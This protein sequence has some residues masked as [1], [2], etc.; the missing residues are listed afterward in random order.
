MKRITWL[1]SALWIGA[2]APPSSAFT[3]L[4]LATGDEA[5]PLDG[6]SAGMG[7]TRFAQDTRGF[8]ASTNPALLTRLQRGTVSL[9]LGAHRLKET[10]STPAFDSFESF[11]VNS[12]YALNN[13]PKYQGG[14]GVAGTVGQERLPNG[15]G[16]GLSFGPVW[17]YQYEFTQEIRSPDPFIRPRDQLIA[18]NDF[19]SDGR[20]D[21]WTLGVGIAPWKKFEFG[22]S[23][24]FLEGSQELLQRVNLV[25]EETVTTEAASIHSLTGGRFILGASLRATPH[26]DFAALVKTRATLDGNFRLAGSPT[27]TP[28]V[29]Q[30][31]PSSGSAEIRYPAQ[32][33]FGV[34]YYPRAKVRTTVTLDLGYTSWSDYR[35]TLHPGIDLDDTWDARVG[36]EHVFRE[37]YPMRFGFHYRPSPQDLEIAS[38]A[39]TFGLGMD[40]WLL[41][42]DLAIEIS[43]RKYRIDRQFDFG[44]PPQNQRD[45]LEENGLSLLLALSLK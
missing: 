6:R 38:T 17:D 30:V 2:A 13:I 10:R 39:F 19:R 42:T 4:E 27:P 40:L 34:A 35:H 12:I 37:S 11:L 45:L 28:P 16:L 20:I 22:V 43:D 33:G 25:Q 14:L 21:G 9:S 7:R 15:I 8:T 41:T 31:P 3:F 29:G 18:L 32:L 26:F 36:I 24:Q 5:L 44:E 1:L 23:V